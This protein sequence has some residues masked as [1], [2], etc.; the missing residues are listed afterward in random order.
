M[1]RGDSRWKGL[2]RFCGTGARN[3]ARVNAAVQTFAG[4]Y[5]ASATRGSLLSMYSTQWP[6]PPAIYDC[7]PFFHSRGTKRVDGEVVKGQSTT[8]GKSFSFCFYNCHQGATLGYYASQNI[9]YYELRVSFLTAS[10]VQQ[11]QEMVNHED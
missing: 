3:L 11:Q 7:F 10:A 8:R 5:K 4:V 2:V 1:E 6:L 9:S